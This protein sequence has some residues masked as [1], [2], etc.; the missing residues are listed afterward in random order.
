MSGCSCLQ[1][2]MHINIEGNSSVVIKTVW[3]VNMPKTLIAAKFCEKRRPGW[4]GKV[5]TSVI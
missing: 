2:T 3:G 5:E 1:N 4:D